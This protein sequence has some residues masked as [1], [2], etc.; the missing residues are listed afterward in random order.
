MIKSITKQI[1]SYS[2]HRSLKLI[3]SFF[4]FIH[5]NKFHSKILKF[6]D[7]VLDLVMIWSVKLKFSSCK[8]WIR[9]Q[10]IFSNKYINCFTIFEE[11]NI[12]G[13]QGQSVFLKTEKLIILQTLKILKEAKFILLET[14]DVSLMLHLVLNSHFVFNQ[15]IFRIKIE[16]YF[17]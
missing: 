9:F 17:L 5:F 7:F 4:K 10:L 11:V 14:N 2:I 3:F 12:F 15:T 16:F 13:T 8:G 1:W 6:G